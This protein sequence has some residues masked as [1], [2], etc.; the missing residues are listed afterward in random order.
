MKPI[1]Y[2]VQTPAIDDLVDHYG[3]HFKDMPRDDR[4][5]LIACLALKYYQCRAYPGTTPP[6][7][8]DMTNNMNPDTDRTSD[9][10]EAICDQLASLT[11]I[12]CFSLLH[13]LTQFEV[14]RV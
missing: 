14:E 11:G 13:A 9:D 4:N 3:N 7:L 1:E 2:F 8:Y 6:A 10:F 5:A 12:E